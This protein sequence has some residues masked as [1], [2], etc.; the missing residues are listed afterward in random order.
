V[1]RKEKTPQRSPRVSPREVI[2]CG[3]RRGFRGGGKVSNE[4]FPTM[5]SD[6]YWGARLHDAKEK[7]DYVDRVGERSWPELPQ[8]ED[9]KQS[10]TEVGVVIRILFPLSRKDLSSGG[11]SE[12][13]FSIRSRKGRTYMSHLSLGGARLHTVKRRG[14]RKR[15]S[16]G[17]R[18]PRPS[19]DNYEEL[20]NRGGEGGA[21]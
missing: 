17:I 18:N 15:V 8:N 11:I 1:L 9:I 4:P 6:T 7:K 14:G 19:L 21:A 2:V 13:Y 10:A 16:K 5:R 20:G 3:A 12:A